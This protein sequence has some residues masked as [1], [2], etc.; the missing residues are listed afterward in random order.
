MTRIDEAMKTKPAPE[1]TTAFLNS[2]KLQSSYV[3]SLRA[4]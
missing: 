4:F 3:L 2:A 1:G